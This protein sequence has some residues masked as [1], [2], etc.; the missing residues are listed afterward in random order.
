[1][2]NIKVMIG[3]LHTDLEELGYS[4]HTAHINSEKILNCLTETLQKV[5]LYVLKNGFLTTRDEIHFF[6]DVRPEL[7]SRITYITFVMEYQ[8]VSRYCAEV[9]EN[10]IKKMTNDFTQ[11]ISDNKNHIIQMNRGLEEDKRK[12]FIR[13][14]FRPP[15][16][17]LGN[18]VRMDSEFT[19]YHSLLIQ[20]IKSNELIHNFLNQVKKEPNTA[21]SNLKWTGKKVSLI[22][23][24][25]A[26]YYSGVFN[27]GKMDIKSLTKSFEHFFNVKLGNV[28]RAFNEIKNRNEPTIFLDI[29]K[30]SIQNKV[31]E[32][33]GYYPE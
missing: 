1:M 20:K 28:Y 30:T 2:K 16:N 33:E 7:V 10:L 8:I 13:K 14:N 15:I 6:E 22:E 29:L 12:F 3:Q 18:L 31:D 23:L 4:E 9:R 26:L 24:M 11:L 32:E 19:T 25:Y 27:N 5:R 21:L 17:N